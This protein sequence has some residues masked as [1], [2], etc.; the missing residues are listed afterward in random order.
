[1]SLLS[2]GSAFSREKWQTITATVRHRTER[3]EGSQQRRS[4]RRLDGGDGL[5][6][7]DLA[8]ENYVIG[9]LT[10]QRLEQK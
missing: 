3:P 10:G 7:D 9:C 2:L 8:A 4:S 5:P 1:M 6:L